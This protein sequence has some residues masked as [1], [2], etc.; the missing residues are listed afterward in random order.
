MNQILLNLVSNAY[1]FTEA[2]GTI[3]VL[4]KE[5]SRR[6]KTAFFQFTVSDTGI[7]M[8]EELK[9]R[10]FR[11]FEQESAT[12]AQKHGGSGLGLSIAK[13]LVDMMHGAIKVDSEKG[14]GTTFTVDI[15][16]EIAD[17]PINTDTEKLNNVK[18]LIVDDDRQALDYTA[19][20]LQRIGV[21]YE[22]ARSGDEA[23]AIM[24]TAKE[25]G[26]GF[27]ICFV[28]WKMPGMDGIDV[29][30]QIRE[31]YDSDTVII[32]MSAYD[33]NEIE[34][35][36]L[37]A[38][39]D[40]FV[41]KPIFQ[42]T[43]FNVL[44]NLTGGTLTK[45]T[46]DEGA[47]DFKGKKVLLAEDNELNA[48]IATEL[49]QMVDLELEHAENGQEA[50]DMFT[51]SAPGTFDII[52]MDVQMPVMDGYEASRAIRNSDH[53]QAKTIPIYAMTA[54]AFNED[55]S[56]AL[57]AGMNGHIAKPIDTAVLYQTIAK[58]LK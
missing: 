16:F 44:M 22:T 53:P 26:H 5:T 32:I 54:N 4:V 34:D 46:A 47:F 20:V 9:A 33:P 51:K 45:K 15:P 40:L 31:K 49:L 6:E 41:P 19:L 11:P 48:E 17:S 14:K 21:E 7:G 25:A 50:V 28:D 43:V 3:R 58:A 2:G 39:V 1:K 8:T 27:D 52:L 23:L 13:N 35:E 37:K 30:R 29:T 10:L 36:A 38:G 42:S 24:Q 18:A 57:S 12:T 56:S 55:I